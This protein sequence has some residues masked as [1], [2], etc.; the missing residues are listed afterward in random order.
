MNLQGDLN[1]HKGLVPS[2]FLQPF[3]ETAEEA[4]G[5]AAMDHLVVMDARRDPQVSL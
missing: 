1:G 3:P 4:A 5:P 2:N